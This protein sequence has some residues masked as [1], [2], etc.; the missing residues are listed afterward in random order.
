MLDFNKK[1]GGKRQDERSSM[2][3]NRFQQNM[4]HLRHMGM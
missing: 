1:R 3:S 2:R 4:E